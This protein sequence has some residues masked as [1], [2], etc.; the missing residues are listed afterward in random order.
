MS[1]AATRPSK[2]VNYTV[3]AGAAYTLCSILVRGVMKL[4][5]CL[6]IDDASPK[7]STAVGGFRLLCTIQ[8]LLLISSKVG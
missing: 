6:G 5:L 1:H 8:G 7:F 4:I 3:W 2:Y